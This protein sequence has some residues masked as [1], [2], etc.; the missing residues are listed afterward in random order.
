MRS[1]LLKFIPLA[2]AL[3]LASAAASAGTISADSAGAHIGQTVA[4]RGTV[5]EVGHSGSGT[6]FLDFGAPYPNAVFTAVIFSDSTSQFPSIE[7]AEGK[8]V[9][10]NG[11]VQ[12]YRG[13]PEIILRSPSQLHY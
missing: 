1:A 8:T 12:L 10:V 3:A 9:T 5:A 13:R 7:Q 2:M 11:T 4:V 6:V